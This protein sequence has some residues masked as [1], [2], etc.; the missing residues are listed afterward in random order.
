MRRGDRRRRLLGRRI[1]QLNSRL[2]QVDACPLFALCVAD[3][4]D[5][6]VGHS[7]VATRAVHD[8]D[9]RLAA[10]GQQQEAGTDRDGDGRLELDPKQAALDPVQPV[11]WKIK[12]WD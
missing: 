10:T 9:R 2:E 8:G 4:R 5:H 3:T 12:E 11:Y 6:Q 7:Q 1:R